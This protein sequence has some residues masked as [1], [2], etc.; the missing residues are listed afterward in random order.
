M[1]QMFASWRCWAVRSVSF[2]QGGYCFGTVRTC[3]QKTL[4]DG[5]LGT[6]RERPTRYLDVA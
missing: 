6:G 3:G 1:P 5:D 2:G 4:S